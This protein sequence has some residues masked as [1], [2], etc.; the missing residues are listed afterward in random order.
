MQCSVML[1]KQCCRVLLISAVAVHH[2][3]LPVGLPF[4][5]TVCHRAIACAAAMTQLCR[6]AATR[7]V[8]LAGRR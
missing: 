8:A 4:T 3:Y 2:G 7:T 1:S 6:L 5:L